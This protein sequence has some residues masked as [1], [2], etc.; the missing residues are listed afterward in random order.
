[1]K[2]KYHQ[3]M[4]NTCLAPNPAYHDKALKA[5]FGQNCSE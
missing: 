3:I 1:M 5:V 4:D 2:E